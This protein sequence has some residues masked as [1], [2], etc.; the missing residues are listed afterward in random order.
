MNT[1]IEN[2][3]IKTRQYARRQIQWFKKEKIDLIIDVSQLT[4]K[5][6]IQNVLNIFN[7][8]K[9]NTS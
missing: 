7:N 3:V 2:I 4:N 9:Y 5:Q 8:P 1:L 6:A